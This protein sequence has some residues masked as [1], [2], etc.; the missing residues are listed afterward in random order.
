MNKKPDFKVR[1][2]LF[3]NIDTRIVQAMMI[4][5]KIIQLF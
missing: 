4:M 5:M 2:Q 1:S 3:T